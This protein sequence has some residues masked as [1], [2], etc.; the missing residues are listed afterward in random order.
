LF[1][2]TDIS[3]LAATRAPDD[4]SGADEGGEEGQSW[5]DYV[6]KCGVT[7]TDFGHNLL[8]ITR[9]ETPE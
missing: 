1:R 5:V 9:D 3:N 4:F 6:D 7:L 8:F 2:C